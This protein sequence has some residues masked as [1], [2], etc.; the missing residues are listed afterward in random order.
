MKE[1]FTFFNE[2]WNNEPSTDGDVL[3]DGI[4]DYISTPKQSGA[5]ED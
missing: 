4:Y 1:Q 3:E 2:E 5:I